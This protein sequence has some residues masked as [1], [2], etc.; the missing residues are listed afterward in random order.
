MIDD[1][2][3]AFTGGLLDSCGNRNI[4]MGKKVYNY[5]KDRG[6]VGAN[7]IIALGTNGSY[8]TEELTNF[9]NEIGSDHTIWLITN[10]LT[11]NISQE[12]N[13]SIWS[14]AP[15]FDN[16]KVIDWNAYSASHDE[17]VGSDGIHLTND[18]RKAY[19]QMIVEAI[20]DNKTVEAARKKAD[21]AA[22]GA[23]TAPADGSM[24]S[25]MY[26]SLLQGL[27]PA[28]QVSRLS[29]GEAIPT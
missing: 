6:E 5:Y 24:T 21:E 12:T 1:Y 19:T 22:G 2:H 11:Q 27:T 16:V 9:I 23:W 13:K 14:V 29:T 4:E 8:S 10:R 15:N 7:V 26:D 20:G 18:G 25:E 3:Q 28:A 17:W